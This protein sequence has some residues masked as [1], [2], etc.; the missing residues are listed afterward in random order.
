MD[1]LT[2]GQDEQLIRWLREDVT[3]LRE[4]AGRLDAVS[5]TLEM[6]VAAV[7]RLE[8]P[9][10]DLT[11]HLKTHGEIRGRWWSAVVRLVALLAAATIIGTASTLLTLW[12]QG[13]H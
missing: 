6:R 12:S 9:C 11:R 7:E 3:G 13:L 1:S 8:R 10:P 5:R 4:T 2:L